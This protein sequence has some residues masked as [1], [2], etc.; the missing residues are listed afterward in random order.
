VLP[1]SA[2]GRREL[3]TANAAALNA[4]TPVR[5]VLQPLPTFRV[6]C[7]PCCSTCGSSAGSTCPC[8]SGASLP[9]TV[10]SGTVTS[11]AMMPPP[12]A[13]RCSWS[14][15]LAGTGAS[16]ATG[17]YGTCAGRRARRV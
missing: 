14:G 6:C 11:L 17:L 3:V 8:S 16:V 10:S 2:C 15:T 13:A 7:G 9:S 5:W 1:V 12:Y 4:M